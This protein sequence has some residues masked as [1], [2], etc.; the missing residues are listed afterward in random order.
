MGRG[1][2][3][4][5]ILKRPKNE[6]AVALGMSEY[7]W[8]GED[9]LRGSQSYKMHDKKRAE[10]RRGGRVESRTNEEEVSLMCEELLFN[11]EDLRQPSVRVAGLSSVDRQANP[12]T[13]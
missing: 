13:A 7:L 9:H 6:A 2:L 10:W 12:S 4:L 1:R 11:I 5:I 8:P 3:T